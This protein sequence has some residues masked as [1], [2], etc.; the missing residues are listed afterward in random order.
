M[1]SGRLISVA[2]S[3]KFRMYETDFGWGRPRNSE[4]VQMGDYGTFSINEYREEEG[5][6]QIGVVVEREKLDLFN[7]IFEQGFDIH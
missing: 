4:F 6:L 5:G 1:K 3:P 2:G 7:A